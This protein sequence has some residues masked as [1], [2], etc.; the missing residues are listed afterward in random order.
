MSKYA[1]KHP[2]K[3]AKSSPQRPYRIQYS[4]QQPSPIRVLPPTHLQKAHLLRVNKQFYLRLWEDLS[5]LTHGEVLEAEDPSL[6]ERRCSCCTSCGTIF[7]DHI[8]PPYCSKC[9]SDVIW[10][11]LPAVPADEEEEELD[12]PILVSDADELKR[13]AAKQYRR[14]QNSSTF[15]STE[16]L[17][18]GKQAAVFFEDAQTN[19][20]WGGLP[21]V[22][23]SGDYN[24]VTIPDNGKVHL[25]ESLEIRR[26]REEERQREQQRRAR[27]REECERL[28]VEDIWREELEQKRIEELERLQKQKEEEEELLKQELLRRKKARAKRRKELSQ[29]KYK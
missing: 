25:I 13:T 19:E 26:Q 12:R 8:D 14:A 9:K 17:P 27:E 5:R 15:F 2:S 11:V 6:P 22:S 1:S 21:F 4:I 20:L 16:P 29:K 3:Q 10:F 28:L 18:R 24:D 7:V 23:G